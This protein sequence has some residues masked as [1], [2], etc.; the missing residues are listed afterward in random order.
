MKDISSHP[1]FK[2]HPL[3]WCLSQS[4]LRLEPTIRDANDVTVEEIPFAFLVD[5]VNKAGK[6]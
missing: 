1:V 5:C 3:P 2:K 4:P 6:P